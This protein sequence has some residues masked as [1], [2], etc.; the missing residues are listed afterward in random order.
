[1]EGRAAHNQYIHLVWWP[2]PVDWLPRVRSKG[3]LL[4]TIYRYQDIGWI[5]ST[6]EDAPLCREGHRLTGAQ[7]TLKG[8]TVVSLYPYPGALVTTHI[9]KRQLE[10]NGR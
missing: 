4:E 7:N 8:N 1:M 9:W 5:S 10:H 3:P 2:G 6:N